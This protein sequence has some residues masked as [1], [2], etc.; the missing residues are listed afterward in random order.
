[1]SKIAVVCTSDFFQIIFAWSVSY[2]Q[3]PGCSNH[4][5]LSLG[6]AFTSQLDGCSTRATCR[7]WWW[8]SVALVDQT[9][10]GDLSC[11]DTTT[12]SPTWNNDICIAAYL[13]G[14]WESFS[15]TLGGCRN[16]FFSLWFTFYYHMDFHPSDCFSFGSSFSCLSGF[17][18]FFIWIFIPQNGYLLLE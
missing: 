8:I 17:H 9:V 14:L 7:S 12:H 18:F 6:V 13:L 5:L 11:L 16:I 1:M 15:Y 3:F 2:V 4:G 10:P